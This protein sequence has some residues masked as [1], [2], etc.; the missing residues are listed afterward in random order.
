[1]TL[2]P[3]SARRYACT[4]LAWLVLWLVVAAAAL[5]LGA[6][7][8]VW[9]SSAQLSDALRDALYGV[10]TASVV[11]GALALAG[12]AFQALLRNPLA[13]PYILG[14]SGGASLGVIL[15]SLFVSVLFQPIF[16]FL[17]ALVTVGTVYAI[18]QRRGRL[19]PYTLLLSGVILN[20]FYAAV[21]M[22]TMGLVKPETRGDIAYWMMGNIGRFDLQWGL[23]GVVAVLAVGAAVVFAF[24]AKGFNLIAVGEETAGTLGVRV[25]RVRHVTFVVA[26]LVTGAAVALT[27]PIGFV[28][29][30]VPH[31]L[32]MVVGPDHRRLVPASFFFGATFLV[33]ANLATGL[34]EG[35]VAPFPPPPVGVLT[36]MCGGPFF[37]YLLRTRWRR[38]AEVQ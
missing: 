13:S 21:I 31:L 6:R 23:V 10:A 5:V 28:G 12:L 35:A 32:R 26:S 27:G 36:A 15:S 24:L 7:V 3:L 20:A 8:W 16:G 2:R 33:L 1:M 19:E 22:L 25:D 38:T 4:V 37:V 9:E 29:L 18:A 17:G 34:L 30:I 11:G 14:V